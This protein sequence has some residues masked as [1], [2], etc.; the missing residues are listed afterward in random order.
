MARERC[1]R[2][3]GLHT[4]LASN[5]LN[6]TYMVETA[7]MLLERVEWLASQLDISF[8]FINIGGGLGIP[9][10]P[11]KT[12]LALARLGAAL[13]ATLDL[14]P[15]RPAERTHPAGRAISCGLG[16]LRAAGR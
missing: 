10:A 4:M 13:A 3:F 8:D 12:P 9:Y 7:R 2:R 14:D 1:A 16:S 15:V 5:E 11:D 6:Y